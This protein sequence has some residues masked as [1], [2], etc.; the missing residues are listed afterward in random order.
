MNFLELCKETRRRCGIQGSGPV[1]VVGQTGMMES[2]VKWV[3]SADTSIQNTF[4]DWKFLWAEWSANTSIDQNIYIGNTDLGS[5]DIESFS[6]NKGQVDG[7]PL[8]YVEYSRNYY[9]LFSGRPSCVSV[10][11][12]NALVLDCKPDDVYVIGAE[13]WKKPQEMTENTS[14]SLIPSQF[15]DAIVWRAVMFFA[16]E[17][18]YGELLARAEKE[19]FVIMMSLTAHSAPDSKHIN[20]MRHPEIVVIP[21]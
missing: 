7:S 3:V 16:E 4:T 2:V 14:V 5:W 12:D 6:I 17:E 21:Q 13:Y 18:D 11:N 8:S 1:T 19:F 9:Q 10:R 20:Q 15:H